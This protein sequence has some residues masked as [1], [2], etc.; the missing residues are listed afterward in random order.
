MKKCI[1][2][3]GAL[4]GFALVSQAQ[5]YYKSGTFKVIDAVKTTYYPGVMGAPITTTLSFKLVMKTCAKLTLDS[6]WLDGKADKV[7]L[8]YSNRTAF[9]GKPM[10]GDTVIVNCSYF[11]LPEERP[12]NGPKVEGSPDTD[13]PAKHTGAALFRYTLK[14]KRYYFSIKDVK[15]GEGVYAP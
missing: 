13:P 1:A 11:K 14:G 7:E 8:I 10:Q 12:V 6:F 2:F 5:V 4:I 3:T 9:D 15:K